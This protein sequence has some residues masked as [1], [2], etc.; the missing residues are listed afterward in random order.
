VSASNANTLLAGA[1]N[2]GSEYL[3]PDAADGR[4][5][6]VISWPAVPIELVRAAGLRPIVVRGGAASTPAADA[7]LRDAAFPSRIRHLVES[8][9]A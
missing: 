6:V 2:D 1:F 4:P 7:H 9:L 3:E 5:S 8:M